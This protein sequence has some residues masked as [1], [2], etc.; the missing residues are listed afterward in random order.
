MAKVQF[1]GAN[2]KIIVDDTITELDVQIDLYSDWKE[3]LKESDNSKYL[4][5]MRTVG[6][7]PTTGTKSVAPYFFLMNG[8]KIRP[9]EGDHT[10]T[11]TG[12]LFVDEPETYGYNLTIPTIGDYTVT[13]MLST[14][15]DAISTGALT[16]VG[17]ESNLTV[18]GALRVILAALAGNAT[19]QNNI[20]SFKG[21]NTDKTRIEGSKTANA[22]NVSLIDG[23]EE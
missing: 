18:K 17:V 4:I 9:Y 7:D 11:I 15:S 19:I 20:F 5:A 21:V 12:N 6:G 13:V 22:R 23:S 10:L 3:W 14:T 1:D 8:W 2:K 16:D